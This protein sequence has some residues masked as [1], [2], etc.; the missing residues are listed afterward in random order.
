MSLHCL[1]SVYLS[2][3]NKRERMVPLFYAVT[4]CCNWLINKARVKVWD[5][6]KRYGET[7]LRQAFVSKWGEAQIYWYK[8]DFFIPMKI[9]KEERKIESERFWN[10][11]M[12]YYFSIQ[13]RFMAGIWLFLQ[14]HICIR[15]T[16]TVPSISSETN[17]AGTK[18]GT[19]GIGTVAIDDVTDGWRGALIG[20]WNRHT[21]LRLIVHTVPARKSGAPN[22]SVPQNICSAG[23]F[24]LAG[25]FGKNNMPFEVLLTNSCYG[26]FVWNLPHPCPLK[27]LILPYDHSQLACDVWTYVFWETSQ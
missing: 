14:K 17:F 25:R 26:L 3:Q 24:F 5:T 22:G 11:E 21:N 10:S 13:V 4:I 16:S 23:N 27:G 8:N 9:K 18:V 2:R 20:I 19:K 12:A 7:E 1:T 6:W 15:L